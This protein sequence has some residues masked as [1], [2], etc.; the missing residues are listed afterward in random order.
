MASRGGS[1]RAAV[2]TRRIGAPSS[3]ALPRLAA[4]LGHTL[5]EPS[6]RALPPLSPPPHE[7]PPRV[8]S[9]ILDGEI[10]VYDEDADN[11]RGA[12]EAFTAR[13]GVQ[14]MAPNRLGPDRQALRGGRRRPLVLLF[15]AIECDGHD[16]LTAR[17]PLDV[18]RAALREAVR[19]PIRGHVEVVK[20]AV[21]RRHGDIFKY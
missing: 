21:C 19:L 17:A 11:G 20:G 5:I 2:T 16:F 4:A 12:I 13:G 6:D 15:D 1:S 14:A 7:A 3:L 9:C 18:R 8:T 10:V